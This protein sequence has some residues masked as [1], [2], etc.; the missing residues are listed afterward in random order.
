[1]FGSGRSSGVSANNG[2]S[3]ASS[4]VTGDLTTSNNQSNNT[5]NMISSPGATQIQFNG[6]VEIK[7]ALTTFEITDRKFISMPDGTYRLTL[8]AKHTG[9]QIVPEFRVTVVKG[10]EYLQLFYP[11]NYPAINVDPLPSAF[12]NGG[13]SKNVM[14]YNNLPSR[15]YVVTITFT[16]KPPSDPEIVI[17]P[18]K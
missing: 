17:S 14:Y 10:S 13:H 2:N 16:Q 6:P 7:S 4:T 18:S 3:F 9:E 12:V 1:M 15:D 11:G 5:Q 8:L